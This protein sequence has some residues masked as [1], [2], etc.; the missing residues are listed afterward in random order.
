MRRKGNEREEREVK[1]VGSWE[2]F[3]YIIKKNITPAMMS[4]SMSKR[5]CE[6]ELM[7]RVADEWVWG[8]EPD[9]YDGRRINAAP[10][11]DGCCEFGIESERKRREPEGEV[12]R[13]GGEGF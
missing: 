12:V 10:R 11:S 13:A 4:Q 1:G 5:D 6:Y 7:S 8:N 2:E 9:G 3:C